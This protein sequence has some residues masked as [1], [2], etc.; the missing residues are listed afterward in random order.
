MK[1]II[2]AEKPNY[3]R[4]ITKALMTIG[5]RFQAGDGY[6][7]SRNYIITWA[8]GHLL[9]LYSIEDYDDVDSEYWTE[10]ILPYSPKEF[11]FKLKKDQGMIKQYNII[12]SLMSR[13]DVNTVI[14][15]GDKDDEGCHLISNLVNDI[16]RNLHK[17]FIEKR[18]WTDDQTE[19]VIVEGMKNLKDVSFYDNYLNSS[20]AR[21]FM[22]FLLGINLTRKFT[23]M[24]RR[25][26]KSKD[27][28]SL[29]RCNTAVVNIV[30]DADK[31]IENFVPV[32]YYQLE[33]E[34]E[35]N[36]EIIKLV[37]KEK[38]SLEE[39]YKSL[40]LAKKL[41]TAGAKVTNIE[42]KIVKKEPKNLFSLPTI[43]SHLSKMFKFTMQETLNIIQKL[44]EEGYVTYPRTDSEFLTNAEKERVR[45]IISKLKKEGINVEMKE[46]SKVFND[47][48][49]D[50]HSALIITD[51]FPDESKLSE[52]ELKVYNVIKNRFISNFFNEKTEIS[53]TIIEIGILDKIFKLKGEYIQSEGFF[54]FE[55]YSK[56]KDTITLPKLN[57]GDIVNINFKPVIKKTTPP[58]KLTISELG[59][60]LANPFKK[61]F[62]DTTDE[63]RKSVIEGVSIGTPATR[64]GIIENTKKYGY[65]EENKGVLSITPKGAYLIE[66]L[67]KINMNLTKEKTVEFSKMIKKVS[68]NEL[69][70]ND[71]VKEVVGELNTIFNSL[72]ETQLGTYKGQTPEIEVIGR[73]PMCGKQVLEGKKIFYCEG[74]KDEPP[75]QFKMW[76]EDKFFKSKGKKLTKS[77]A[78][79]LLANGQANMTGLMKKDNSGKYS[80]DVVLRLNGNYVNYELKFKK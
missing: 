74:Y 16:K 5:E 7:E 58:P 33:S 28:F 70:V 29:G 11:K 44:Y 49:V 68:R 39:E 57:V 73:C 30:Y 53:Q 76:K 60:I 66:S 10:D 32:K 15:A 48:L 25:L 36:K 69:T 4:A 19:K 8:Y 6:L 38:F 42:N 75:C 56:K 71:C 37:D 62:K 78:K 41:N 3:G 23:L 61:E 43:Q 80:A 40:E 1:S 59:K 24:N 34:E 26:N 77:V 27:I 35:T 79:R 50:A 46:N 65:I 31:A 55:P 9:E 12:K 2:I 54:K 51:K 64:A 14:H 13:D 63:F 47:K 18:L 17:S 22:D 45:P 67:K 72:N 52:K 21:T 20:R